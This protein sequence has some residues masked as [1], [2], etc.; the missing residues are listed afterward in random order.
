M[1][2]LALTLTTPST[3][4]KPCNTLQLESGISGVGEE[5]ADLLLLRMIMV[6]IEPVSDGRYMR[7]VPVLTVEPNLIRMVRREY[8]EVWVQSRTIWNVSVMCLT[9]T[10]LH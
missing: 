2:T 6:P 1:T 4:S 9:F 5:H 8:L 10:F 7:A 3:D